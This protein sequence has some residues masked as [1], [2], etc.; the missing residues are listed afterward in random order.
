MN[1]DQVKALQDGR[2]N[3]KL[4]FSLIYLGDEQSF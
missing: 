4:M 1:R 3:G 2:I